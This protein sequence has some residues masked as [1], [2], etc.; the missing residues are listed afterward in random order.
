MV[1]GGRFPS[2]SRS[3]AASGYPSPRTAPGPE[4]LTG[5]SSAIWML[6]GGIGLISLPLI[7]LASWV[8]PYLPG[9]DA[10]W[11]AAF[12]GVFFVV[13]IPSSTLFFYGLVKSGREQARGYTTAL[14][15]ARTKP[16]L[17]FYHPCTM[18]LVC[19]PFES[20]PEK[21]A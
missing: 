13:L 3:D 5:R 16:A 14:S 4:L 12:L 17:F 2:A 9:S 8:V 18:A 19:R 15:V 20:R 11:L 7:G 10:Y 6:R 21:L 1:E